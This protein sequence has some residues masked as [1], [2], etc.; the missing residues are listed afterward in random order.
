M[1]IASQR[2]LTFAI[3]ALLAS[4]VVFERSDRGGVGRWLMIK[5]EPIAHL[6]GI[7]PCDRPLAYHIG[8]FDERFGLSREQFQEVINQAAGIWEQSL[9]KTLFLSSADKGFA[10]NLLYDYR[11][12]TTEQLTALGFVIKDG[13]TS[14]AELKNQYNSL[15]TSYDAQKKELENLIA[16]FE[17]RKSVYEEDVTY[18]NSKGGAP[19]DKYES[20]QKEKSYLDSQILLINQRQ[21]A[22]S[23]NTENLNVMAEALNKLA[24]D[25]NTTVDTYNT[26][27]AK[28]G[29]E[30]E[31]GEYVLDRHGQ[32]INIY[33][34]D[35]GKRLIRVLAHELG[36]VLGM[37]HVE[38]PDAIMYRLNQGDSEKATAQDFIEL[39][40]VCGI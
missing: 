25:F 29:P 5:T 19:R 36:H 13:K 39:K 31:E 26:I 17:Q 23:I 15:K 6:L 14:Y 28:T 21:K 22:L 34:F 16:T 24:K 11:Q 40:R 35:S 27:G 2:L 12:Q 10:I 3:L 18:W 4:I 37:E 32:R 33:Q 1:K 7:G 9:D 20:L 30:F 38:D 8:A